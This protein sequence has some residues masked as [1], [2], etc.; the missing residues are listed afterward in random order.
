MTIDEL[1]SELRLCNVF[2]FNDVYYAILEKNGRLSVFPR[3][4]PETGV[5]R[6]LVIDGDIIHKNLEDLGYSEA[7]L[8]R[9]LK[10][11]NASLSET[12][13]FAAD[14]AENIYFAK[15]E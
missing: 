4:N 2:D 1:I 10:N 3:R 6:P 8:L 13:V 11:R 12:F 7:W 5:M 14:D 9:Q 15:K